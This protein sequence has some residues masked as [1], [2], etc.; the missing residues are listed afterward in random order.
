MIGHVNSDTPAKKIGLQAD[1]VILAVNGATVNYYTLATTIRQF[2]SKEIELTWRRGSEEI[3]TRVTPTSEGRIGVV[4]EPHFSGPVEHI[5]YSIVG[6]LG[7]GVGDLINLTGVFFRNIH[8]IIVGTASFSD[9]I[10]GPVRIAQIAT[11][12]AEVGLTAYLLVMAM[13]SLSLAI[14]NVLPFPALD[15]GHLVFLTYEGIFRREIPSKVKIALQQVGFVLLLVFMAFVLY[16][17]I[18]RF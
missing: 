18:A 15:G 8:A 9:S 2:A 14:L 6:A 11:R 12:S 10:G 7:E 5:R 1:D 16:N 3:S 13:L 4:L 17:D